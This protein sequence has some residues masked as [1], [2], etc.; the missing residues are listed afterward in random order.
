MTDTIDIPA[1]FTPIS[2]SGLALTLSGNRVYTMSSVF[3]SQMSVDGVSILS[4]PIQLWAQRTGGSLQQITAT[5][6]VT[7]S[8]SGMV[9][10]GWT[11]AGDGYTAR[12]EIKVYCEGRIQV[13]FELDPDA[14]TAWDKLYLIVP[15]DSDIPQ[16][17]TKQPRYNGT[18]TNAQAIP[19]EF[20]DPGQ[21]YP[22][23][24]ASYSFPRAIW[25]HNETHGFAWAQDTDANYQT[26]N[27]D[28]DGSRR[29]RMAVTNGTATGLAGTNQFRIDIIRRTTS[30]TATTLTYRMH[31]M[32]TPP[33]SLDPDDLLTRLGEESSDPALTQYR[34][35]TEESGTYRW[36][37]AGVFINPTLK[38]AQRAA[39]I[40]RGLGDMIDLIYNNWATAE[41]TWDSDWQ[42]PYLSGWINDP[43]LG[44]YPQ[45]PQYSTDQ[46]GVEYYSLISAKL[47]DPDYQQNYLDRL[48]EVLPLTDAIYID[49][50]DYKVESQSLDA[51]GRG[52]YTAVV[53]VNCDFV[54]KIAARVRAAGKKL[55]SH[56][57]G[58]FCPMRDCFFDWV[59]PGEQWSDDLSSLSGNAY[60][61]FYVDE[62]DEAQ[63]KAEMNAQALGTHIV[64]LPAYAE[65][66]HTTTA[67]WFM[68]EA[69]AAQCVLNQVGIW[70][71]NI[72]RAP[73][74]RL[75]AAQKQY[76]TGRGL[77]YSSP[78]RATLCTT[79]DANAR[80]ATYA[81]D[82]VL[83]A[84]IVNMSDT[85]RTVEVS[86]SRSATASAI[87]YAGTGQSTA[88][89]RP[90]PGYTATIEGSGR[91][92]SVGVG[93]K[94]L[95]LVEFT[96]AP[97]TNV[98]ALVLA[99]LKNKLSGGRS[100]VGNLSG[101]KKSSIKMHGGK[102]ASIKLPGG[103]L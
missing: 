81:V 94:N 73:I 48:D 46:A 16:Y 97:P 1:P 95:T 50:T 90:S 36:H 35:L 92:F 77:E 60:R 71:T 2:R 32:A 57:Q 17:M 49:V 43:E 55:L 67:E 20:K 103:R 10:L 75:F 98:L 40:E 80:V 51:F 33:K 59:L 22:G 23:W 102:T 72:A 12:G 47:S 62:I 44:G 14:S 29:A 24:N 53:G 45:Y 69:M 5:P 74:R 68:T 82:N 96:L 30:A 84:A 52:Y 61:R 8:E 11:F 9:T 87:R 38:A 101:G 42:A 18:E 76:M 88:E 34:P 37:G 70:Y 93:R 7:A 15:L 25:V 28:G 100:G 39:R 65:S 4:G 89:S 26:S 86:L 41:P 56:A 31:F 85:D 6:S 64:M 83:I 13:A 79:A 99:A 3:C 19:W 78:S 27:N 66:S 63:W 91:T 21:T 54:R 58:D